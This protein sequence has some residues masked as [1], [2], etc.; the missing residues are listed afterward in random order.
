MKM[1]VNLDNVLCWMDEIYQ[2]GVRKNGSYTRLAYSP[3]DIKGR[4]KFISFA[5]AMGLSTRID[6][7]GNIIVKLAGKKPQW[8]CI[9]IG[10][11]LDTVP[12][13][14]KY[15]G[16][17]GCSAGLG[18]CQALMES[19]HIPDH[20]LEIIIF[21]DEEGARFGGGLM[22]ST[23]FSGADAGFDFSDMGDDGKTREEVL[24][25]F[26]LD[27]SILSQAARP[28][29]TVHCF[30]ELHIE[31]GASL[32]N[33]KV[34]IGI[35][36]SIV[37][38]KRYE[39]T[40]DGQSNH[41]GSTMMEDRKDALLASAR[42]ISLIPEIIRNFGAGC[43]VATVGS[44][45][46]YPG[47][48]NV[49]PGKCVFSLEIRDKDET[50]IDLV[51]HEL[52]RKLK[53]ICQSTIDEYAIRL[54]SSHNPSPMAEWVQNIIQAACLAE[55]KEYIYLPSGAFHDSLM[56]SG[57]FPTGMIFIPSVG[58]VS[59]SPE[60]FSTEEDIEAGLNVL[61]KSVLIADKATGFD[62]P[63]AYK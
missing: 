53:S 48:V 25:E 1:K 49:V 5:K 11:H 56:M 18:V 44:I 21:T 31:Q 16:L 38:V 50:I 15:D 58:G 7:A 29:N 3:E 4:Q 8:P 14:G 55:E 43:T 42:F 46:A 2:C 13:G 41:A 9:L 57:V 54:V 33:G 34:P 10:S 17:L 27:T 36:S 51:E 61:L 19:D 40:I 37:G 45:K 20:S 35:V 28:K 22:G 39:I 6:A 24:A 30:L 63:E 32:Y 52:L 60:E 12:G 47:S 23:Y 59:H 26:G 62:K